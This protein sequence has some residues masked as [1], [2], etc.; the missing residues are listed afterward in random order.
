MSVEDEI[1]KLNAEPC[2]CVRCS[3]CG[4]SGTVRL[5]TDSW[6]EWDL[7]TCDECQGSGIVEDCDRCLFLSELEH[8]DL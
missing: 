2:T 6:P 4:G 7:D 8:D 5:E 1:A 3:F